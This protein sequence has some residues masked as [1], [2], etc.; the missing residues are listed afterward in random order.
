MISLEHLDKRREARRDS[1]QQTPRI[2]GDYVR[3][4]T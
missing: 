1:L 4:W 3:Q 2:F